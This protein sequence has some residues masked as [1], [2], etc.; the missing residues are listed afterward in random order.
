ML[1]L[2]LLA[3]RPFSASVQTNQ[4][5]TKGTNKVS[6]INEGSS[7][8]N[9]LPNRPWNLRCSLNRWR[10]AAGVLPASA[11]THPGAAL[12]NN[13]RLYCPHSGAPFPSLASHWHHTIATL[14]A[15]TIFL[16]GI[17]HSISPDLNNRTASNS[18]ATITYLPLHW[19]NTIISSSH[20]IY[21][22]RHSRH[23]LCFASTIAFLFK[24]TPC[25]LL[26]TPPPNLR[27]FGNSTLN[28][29]ERS[30]RTPHWEMKWS[31]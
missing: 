3:P 28:L 4:R 25:F 27:E 11:C 31:S 7:M 18:G 29:I 17:I 10:Q 13:F 12:L 24:T 22:I 1:Y 8:W 5:I 26:P 21:L 15:S 9:S 20:C 19:G 14:P 23:P 2:P 30:S 16:F 6:I